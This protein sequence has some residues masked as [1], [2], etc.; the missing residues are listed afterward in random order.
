MAG[1]PRILFR[2][3]IEASPI[4]QCVQTTGK[5]LVVSLA[6]SAACIFAELPMVNHC[7]GG[8]SNPSILFLDGHTLP[9]TLK[10]RECTLPGVPSCP[11]EDTA[12]T[13]G[14]VG[15][16]A[17]SCAQLSLMVAL[18][19][20]CPLA[21]SHRKALPSL[22]EDSSMLVSCG[23]Q[24]RLSTPCTTKFLKHHQSTGSNTRRCSTMTRTG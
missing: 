3:I 5:I 2:C 24:D 16:Q 17:M 4:V 22:P 13:P 10:V 6:N 20:A 7:Q 1:L 9:Q 15:A 23:D 18:P 8:S 12:K 14:M 11:D 21:T 19:R